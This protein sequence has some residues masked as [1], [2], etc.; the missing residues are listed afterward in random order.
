VPGITNDMVRFGDTFRHFLRHFWG[1]F[2]VADL[3]TS[4]DVCAG[5]VTHGE[6]P[7]AARDGR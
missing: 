2:S 7:P 1:S 4:Y 3:C 6:V 5:I